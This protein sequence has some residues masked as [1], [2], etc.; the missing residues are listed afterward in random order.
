R[1][2]S[3]DDAA[4]S[5]MLTALHVL[6]AG[7]RCG[8]SADTGFIQEDYWLQDTA[9]IENVEQRQGEYFIYLVFAH[10]QSPLKFIKRK[11]V[12]FACPRKASMTA[13]YMR[14]QAAK[15]QRGTLTINRDLFNIMF[16]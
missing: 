14:R 10:H 3:L 2:F 9:V 7:D 8:A 13:Y 4:Y 6:N 11:I 15:D 16:S 12:K 1:R 5:S